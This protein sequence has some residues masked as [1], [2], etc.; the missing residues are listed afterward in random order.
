[1]NGITRSLLL[2]ISFVGAIAGSACSNTSATATGSGGNAGN[3]GVG[4]TGVGGTGVGGTGVGGT[5]V[6]GTGVGGTGVGGTGVG[7]TGVAGAATAGKP[8]TNDSAGG[9][10]G[11]EAGTNTVAGAAGLAAVNRWDFNSL[12][13]WT[14]KPADS[15][16]PLR[17]DATAGT[18]L[19]VSGG[20]ARLTVPFGTSSNT[21][22][23]TTA[24]QRSIDPAVSM[25]GLTLT[26]KLRWV[27]GGVGSVA[28][29]EGG[30]DVYLIPSDADWTEGVTGK[31][32]LTLGDRG[33][34]TF[35]QFSYAIPASDATWDPSS[36]QQLQLRIDSKYWLGPVFD[37]T[38]A[39]FEID[40]I[41]Q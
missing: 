16:I 32:E 9:G 39:V 2:A 3:K 5:G 1:M 6:G 7:G 15:F 21:S 13:G 10:A 37:Y 17:I 26:L 35:K 20:I 8:G 24:I 12:D 25:S 30:F 41:A 23:Q 22:L 19:Q 4:G 36:I 28:S 27:S 29:A 14:V 18:T 31:G 38:T 34:A 33:A 40:S 11:G